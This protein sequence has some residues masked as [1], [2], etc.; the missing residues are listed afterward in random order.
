MKTIK[1]RPGMPLEAK[2]IT[3][4][5]SAD[6]D[7]ILWAKKPIQQTTGYWVAALGVQAY[8]MLTAY[9]LDDCGLKPGEIAKVVP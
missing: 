2:Y 8:Y 7:V 1:R 5:R 3:K 9:N 4:D 6:A